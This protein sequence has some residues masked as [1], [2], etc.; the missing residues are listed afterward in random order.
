M[1]E[2]HS[3][4]YLRVHSFYILIL[5]YAFCFTPHAMNKE[6]TM[7]MK[8]DLRTPSTSHPEEDQKSTPTPSFT[9]DKRKQMRYVVRMIV[10]WVL[11]FLLLSLI[12]F[13]GVWLGARLR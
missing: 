9:E 10:T 2:M 7:T 6:K 11:I 4:K 5:Y 3:G 8:A 1:K 13:L 12:P